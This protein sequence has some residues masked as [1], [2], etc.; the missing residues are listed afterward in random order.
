MMIGPS[1]HVTVAN[2]DPVQTHVVIDR[3]NIGH[4]LRAGQ[5]KQI[6]MLNSAVEYFIK[7]N[8]PLSK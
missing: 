3:Y 4:E 7:P 1:T 6:E 2:T 8:F 5:S